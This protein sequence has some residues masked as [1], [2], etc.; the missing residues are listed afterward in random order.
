MPISEKQRA[1]N[2]ANAA[3]AIGPRTPEGKAH[4][5]QNARYQGT[6]PGGPKRLCAKLQ[7]EPNE[8]KLQNEPTGGP[9]RATRTTC[10][11]K[12][13]TDFDPPTAPHPWSCLQIWFSGQRTFP[14]T[15]PT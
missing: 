15:I 8:P 5:A 2:R 1:A 14:N 6:H 10:A 13:P 7:N 9:T 4:F 12:E 11:P 3:G